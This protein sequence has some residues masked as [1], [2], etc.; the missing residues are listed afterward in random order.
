MATLLLTTMLLTFPLP[1][2]A[3][4]P[5]ATITGEVVDTTCYLLHEAKG[6]GHKECAISCVNAGSPAAILDEKTGRLVYPLARVS[7]TEHHAHRPDQKL[8]PFVGERVRVTGT[9]VARAGVTAI[10]V[11]QVERAR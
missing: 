7:Q 4:P 3:S 2:G 8:L 9:L 6:P 10:T 5:E 11:E 1:T